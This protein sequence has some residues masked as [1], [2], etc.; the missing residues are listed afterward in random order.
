MISL[1]I[2]SN[3]SVGTFNTAYAGTTTLVINMPLNRAYRAS[4]I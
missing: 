3:H 1:A 2:A 4:E